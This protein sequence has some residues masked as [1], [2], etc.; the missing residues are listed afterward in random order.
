MKIG[1]SDRGHWN[2]RYIS[3][4]PVYL[5]ETSDVHV[6][7]HHLSPGLIQ[8][9]SNLFQVFANILSILGS[10][11]E[12]GHVY[13]RRIK[14]RT[15]SSQPESSRQRKNKNQVVGRGKNPNP[16]MLA[17]EQSARTANVGRGGSLPPR[18]G[19]TSNTQAET[20]EDVE[21]EPQ[22]EIGPLRMHVLDR[23]GNL[24]RHCISYKGRSLL[25]RSKENQIFLSLIGS[26]LIIISEPSFSRI[27]MS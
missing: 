11:M 13:E 10:V 15:N 5:V 2:F 4:L 21:I 19:G 8:S 25:S 18:R 9:S 26:S 3:E 22:E 7:F 1:T 20:E 23:A 17:I 14:A 27:T 24:P 16:A 6:L 12:G